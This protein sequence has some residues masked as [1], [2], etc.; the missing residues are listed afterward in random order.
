M[1]HAAHLEMFYISATFLR[2]CHPIH[3]AWEINRA[4]VLTSDSDQMR[5]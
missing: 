5:L 4:P 1:V 3:L 2:A